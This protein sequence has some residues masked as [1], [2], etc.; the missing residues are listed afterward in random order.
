MMQ[1]I[2]R[3]FLSS[4]RSLVTFQKFFL[5][6]KKSTTPEFR[7]AII[8]NEYFC[9]VIRIAYSMFLHQYLNRILKQPS[10]NDE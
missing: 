5:L 9:Y 2:T 8:L 4:D 3:I 6:W 7:G 10:M 1:Y